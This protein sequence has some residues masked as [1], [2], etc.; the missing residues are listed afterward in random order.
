MAASDIGFT[1]RPKKKK[2]SKHFVCLPITQAKKIFLAAAMD[3]ES[4]SV[5]LL[6]LSLSLYLSLSLIP[7]PSSVKK[8]LCTTGSINRLS[9]EIECIPRTHHFLGLDCVALWV[10]NSAGYVFAA[11]ATRTAAFGRRGGGGGFH[12]QRSLARSINSKTFQRKKKRFR[13]SALIEMASFFFFFAGRFDVLCR[14]IG[15]FYAPDP[16]LT[17]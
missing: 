16:D 5:R 8:C 17:E 12:P 1:A 7:P 15:C 6:S 11:T 4:F 3:S 13:K 14:R 10:A 2:F 9:D